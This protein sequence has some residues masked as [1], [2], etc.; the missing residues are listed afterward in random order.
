MAVPEAMGG[1]WRDVPASTR[2]ICDVLRTLAGADPSVAL[3]SSMHP[4]VIGFW[5]ARPDESSPAW[6]TQREA[7]FASAADGRQWGTITSVP[8]NP[9]GMERAD[10]G[11][12]DRGRAARVEPLHRG[13]PGCARRSRP[14][15]ETAAGAE[16]R[17]PQALRAGRVEPRGAR[18]LARDAGIRRRVAR[19]R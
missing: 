9:H 4:A 18:V 11:H 19:G 17:E 16:S 14:Y 6:M 2:S 3:V 13:R 10:R 12:H 5:L 1:V 8:G 7:V 15:R